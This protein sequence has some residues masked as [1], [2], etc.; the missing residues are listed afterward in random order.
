MTAVYRPRVQ[1]TS[2]WCVLNCL[3]R[4]ST[5]FYLANLTVHSLIEGQSRRTW[6]SETDSNQWD[7]LKPVR[8]LI[9]KLPSNIQ[10]RPP[11]LKKKIWKI[12]NFW[13]SHSPSPQKK[14]L[15]K[16]TKFNWTSETDS[17]QWD[18]LEP[19][20]RTWTSKTDSNQ[21]DGLEPVRHLI[22]KLPSNNQYRPPKLKKKF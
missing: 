12:Y 14:F 6:T 7:G 9:I 20:R 2:R 16:F 1:F 22:I 17:N 19:V 10:Y 21:W 15:E 11:K 18:G 13:L 3:K 4:L 8:H 5:K